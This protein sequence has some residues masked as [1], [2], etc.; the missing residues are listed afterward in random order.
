M[1][2]AK[3]GPPPTEPVPTGIAN[4]TYGA[5]GRVS[6]A[7]AERPLLYR[8]QCQAS[9]RS[10]HTAAV[11]GFGFSI[12][13]NVKPR[14]DHLIPPPSWA[15]ADLSHGALASLRGRRQAA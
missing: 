9:P 15:S 7:E 6:A 5:S 1:A 13:A 3:V 4:G 12:A 2:S 14:L 10:P 11:L 8:G